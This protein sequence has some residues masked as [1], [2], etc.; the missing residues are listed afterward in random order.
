MKFVKKLDGTH[1]KSVKGHRARID[2]L[3]QDIRDFKEKNKLE[4]FPMLP[5]NLF[6]KSP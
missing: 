5:I 3:R 1:I 4:D 2:A 6:K